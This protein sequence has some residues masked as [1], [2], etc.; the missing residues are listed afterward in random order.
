MCKYNECVYRMHNVYC[1]NIHLF[2]HLWSFCPPNMLHIYFVD[3]WYVS[4]WKSVCAQPPKWNTA[5]ERDWNQYFLLCHLS[6]LYKAETIWTPV[7]STLASFIK[8]PHLAKT[9]T[10]THATVRAHTHTHS[11]CHALKKQHVQTHDSLAITWTLNYFP[12]WPWLVINWLKKKRTTRSCGSSRKPLGLETKTIKGY[13]WWKRPN[14]VHFWPLDHL[15]GVWFT[16]SQLHWKY[17]IINLMITWNSAK[18]K[19]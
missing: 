13:I 8:L 2:I 4:V 11:C 9:H 5:A 7:Y 10:R 15:K 17:K 6:H 1:I 14:E 18:Q 19:I 3:I 12:H 16:H